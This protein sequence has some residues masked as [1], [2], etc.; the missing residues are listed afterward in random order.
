LPEGRGQRAGLG[1]D[2][3]AVTPAVG[4][5]LRRSAR[6]QRRE[7]VAGARELGQPGFDLGQ[8]PADQAGHVDARRLA[9]VTDVQYL[10]DGIEG[11]PGGLGR[12]G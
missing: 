8:A 1:G 2:D 3:R 5:V 7:L 11:E 6:G 4:R 12:A 9:A 10:P